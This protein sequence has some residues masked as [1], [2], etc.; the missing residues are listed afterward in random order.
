MS[1]TFFLLM[2][3]QYELELRDKRTLILDAEK[4]MK[5]ANVLDLGAVF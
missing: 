2:R 3:K 4:L 5:F 1:R